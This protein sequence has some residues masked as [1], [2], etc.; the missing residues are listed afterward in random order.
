MKKREKLKGVRGLE[1]RRIY[2]YERTEV[3]STERKQKG[4]ERWGC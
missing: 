3:P 1:K 2:L 4:K